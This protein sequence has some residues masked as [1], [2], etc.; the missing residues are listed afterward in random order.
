MVILPILTL[1]F[2]DICLCANLDYVNLTISRKSAW[3]VRLGR[4]LRV[5]NGAKKE[6]YFAIQ[7]F[8]RKFAV[9]NHNTSLLFRCAEA[10]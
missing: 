7:R 2:V 9:K 3:S 5:K 1:R 6:H 8:M 10:H 4:T